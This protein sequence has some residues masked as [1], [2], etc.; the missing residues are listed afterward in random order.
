MTTIS[1]LKPQLDSSTGTL[2]PGNISSG[3]ANP[4]V[5][6]AEIHTE[7]GKHP[8]LP[9]APAETATHLAVSELAPHPD[10]DDSDTDSIKYPDSLPDLES[11]PSLP[12]LNGTV[13]PA[14]TATGVLPTA[15]SVGIGVTNSSSSSRRRSC[16]GG[17]SDSNLHPTSPA[18]P[19][20]LPPVPP[21]SD[22]K[23]SSSSSK[24]KRRPQW[25]RASQYRTLDEDIAKCQAS[26]EKLLPIAREESGLRFIV[27]TREKQDVRDAL[28][29]LGQDQCALQAGDMCIMLYGRLVY[30]F[31][32]KRKSDFS[33]SITDRTKKQL[34]K[35]TRLPVARE[36][37]FYLLEEDPPETT[38]QY[39]LPRTTL[40]GAQVNLQARDGISVVRTDSLQDTVLYMCKLML[41]IMKHASFH[42]SEISRFP[43]FDPASW[44]PQE[45]AWDQLEHRVCSSVA[46]E[47]AAVEV[48]QQDDNETPEEAAIR[49][50][51]QEH[52]PSEQSWVEAQL[53]H[54]HVSKEMKIVNPRTCFLV[55]LAQIPGVTLQK[56][57]V[58]YNQYGSWMGLF[59]SIRRQGR[60]AIVKELANLQT[61]SNQEII[62]PP[63]LESWKQ[64]LPAS[65]FVPAAAA[66]AAAA[67]V[68]A[69]TSA[70]ESPSSSPKSGSR[71]SQ[72]SSTLKRRLGP[73]LAQKIVDL[74]APV[75]TMDSSQEEDFINDEEAFEDDDDGDVAPS[76]STKK[77]GQKRKRGR[78]AATAKKTPKTP[79]K[80]KKQRVTRSTRRNVTA[81]A[82]SSAAS[83]SAAGKPTPVKRERKPRGTYKK[84]PLFKAPPPLPLQSP[85]PQDQPETHGDESTSIIDLTD[86]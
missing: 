53:R 13:S 33:G 4:L 48:V 36:R 47:A 76:K 25:N 21:S 63:A 34:F 3:T 46:A 52:T 77:A 55:Q 35:L 79:A 10:R 16:G 39:L 83:A 62:L 85:P 82:A 24:F 65:E 45:D 14:C 66:G 56:A 42:V 75:Y 61:V 22:D 38:K 9:L 12:D 8:S 73:K 17:G 1:N 51:K 64:D 58:V 69:A 80:P 23:M 50:R 11:V 81:G 78:R 32:R 20:S 43:P 2:I 30:V 29:I 54:N 72:S 40:V 49:K 57:R 5:G 71:K 7:A 18:N 41:S 31:E 44:N 70:G 68:A 28:G 59:R 19:Q 67:T 37:L 27:D 74:I 84:L 26:L 60:P 15:A 6:V 86:L